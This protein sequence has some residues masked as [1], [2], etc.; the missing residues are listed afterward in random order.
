MARDF[1]AQV[2]AFLGLNESA[3]NTGHTKAGESP[4]M[5]NLKITPSYS[6]SLREGYECLSESGGEGRGLTVLDGAVYFVSGKTL[7]SY[8]GEKKVIGE[9]ESESGKVSFLHFGKSLY[10][11]DGKKI[12][13]LCQGVLS[14][15]D[16]YVPLIAVS[17]DVAGGGVPFED[18]NL[19]TPK[20]RQSFTVDSGHTLLILAEQNIDSVES[21]KLLG[22]E[23]AKTAYTVNLEKGTV[24]LA[25]NN[26]STEINAYEVT[27]S[28]KIPEENNPHRMR[29]AV[30]WGGDNDTRIF[31]WGDSEK[32][33]V[34]R[35]SGVH[36][37]VSDMDYFP[38]L[39]FNKS[40]TGRPITS[41]V[42]HYDRLLIFTDREAYYS[43]IEKRSDASG[44]EYLSFPVRTLSSEVG[45]THF[46]TAVLVD[47]TPLTLSGTSLYRWVSTTVRDE[48]NAEEIGARIRKGLV[49]LSEG[50]SVFDR[51]SHGEVYLWRED[52]LYVYNYRLDLFY[53]YEG[54]NAAFFHEDGV[55]NCFFLTCDGKL[56]R[57]TEESLDLGHPVD[58]EWE[59]GYSEYSGLDTKNIHSIE[60]EVIPQSSVSF[61]ILW[62]SDTMTGKGMGVGAEYKVLDFESLNFSRFSFKT[63]VTP[64]RLRKRVKLKRQKSFKLIVKSNE[65]SIDFHLVSLC[66]RGRITDAI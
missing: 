7:F 41:L 28:K 27:Y 32:P 12:K 23:M 58:F 15:I 22:E 64:I 56:C 38:E 10:I 66:I 37:G 21:V 18:I 45:C 3:P 1:T 49:F 57:M 61:D 42:R 4:K 39:S 63:A 26:P 30:L 62:A 25:S 31:L 43:Y 48:R 14:D 8:N 6:L 2:N 9:L 59:T 53:Y 33:D 11:L 16:P 5:K 52:K 35:Y 29:Y 51:T 20:R 65:N 34:Y 36:D 40:A 50:L 44:M 13:K 19:L 24:Q 55:G 54:F 60:F 47:N 46:G 17:T